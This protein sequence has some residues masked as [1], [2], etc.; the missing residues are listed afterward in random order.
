MNQNRAEHS[1]VPAKRRK[2]FRRI[3]KIPNSSRINRSASANIDNGARKHAGKAKL[4][5]AGRYALTTCKV[6]LLIF[7]AICCAGAGV[8]G[9][10][11]LGYIRTAE[12][13]T[14]EQLNIKIETSYIYD[15]KDNE[16]AMLTGSLNQNREPVF[17]KDTPE[18]LRKAFIAIE[19]ERFEKHPGIDFRRIASAILGI[20]TGSSS[21]GGSTITQQVVRNITNKT[22]RSVE[23][24]VQEWYLAIKLE[25]VLEKWQIL[26]LYMN[27]IYMG[28][29]CH[30]VQ[31]ASRMYFG[32]DV[33]DLSL[34]EC[35]LLAGITNSP[36]NY[37][38]YNTYIDSG[39]ENAVKRQRIILKKM[40]EL[41]FINQNEYDQALQ[42]E[43]KFVEKDESDKE[44]KVQSYFV[45]YVINEVV[46]DLMEQKG[47]SKQMAL[48]MVYSYGVLIHTTMDP[49]IQKVMDDV[50]MDEKYFH[51]NKEVT[52]H[53]QAGMVVIDPNNGNILAIRGGYGEKKASNILNRA[54][55]IERPAGSSFKPLVDFGP[56]IDRRIITAATIFDDAPVY[57]LGL[58]KKRYPENY[59]RYFEGLMTTRYAVK[60]SVNVPAAKTYL[61]FKDLNIPLEYLRKAGID[62]NQKNLSISLGGLEKGV[63]PLQMAAAYVPFTNRG[64]YYEPVSYTKVTDKDGNIIL[65]KKPAYNA[66]Y[67]EA[68]AF[69]MTD[70][71]KDVCRSTRR[72]GE[73]GGTAAKLGTI[74][75]AKNEIIPTAGKTGTTDDDKDRWFVGYSKYYT[76]A[77]WYGYDHPTPIVGVPN[78]DNPAALIWNAVMQ[79]IHRNKAPLDFPIPSNVVK[80]KIC[81]YSGKIAT[82]ACTHDPRGD[83]SFEEYFIKGTEPADNDF[84]NAHIIAKVCKDA[85]DIWGHNLLAGPDCPQ[86]SIMERVYVARKIPFR[87]MKPGDPY[88][89]DWKYEYP[90]GEYCNVHGYS[91][92][93]TTSTTN[94]QS[95]YYEYM[96]VP[97]QFNH[98]GENEQLTQMQQQE[99]LYQQEKQQQ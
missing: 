34:A 75:N 27:V 72:P 51:Q 32:K 53:P 33:K 10:A 52:Q 92:S 44:I 21:H 28:N 89:L 17:Y 87:P 19:D 88:P 1:R 61:M 86:D 76:G 74:K 26:E 85:K 14:K 2:K 68:T 29:S 99:E 63:S 97:Q 54:T 79:K 50:F 46:N 84:C 81:V 40:L 82:D 91:S 57:F 47:M 22:K 9:G 43:L 49:D 18:Y 38:P 71:L 78:N 25:R 23:R 80:K 45:D 67:D 41:G 13:L 70:M 69:I 6:I 20:V 56:A 96:D 55:Q 39:R 35:A 77:V 90:A 83:A 48:T 37:D 93:S 62:R 59:T 65:E 16:I 24:K 58:D 5:S 98:Q 31:S 15:S 94:S 66:V 64:I 60:R 95:Q 3:K 4:L 36:T 73:L 7:T 8:L 30:G 12:P 42:E 11:I